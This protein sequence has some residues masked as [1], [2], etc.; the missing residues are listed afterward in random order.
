MECLPVDF[1]QFFA[2]VQQQTQQQQ[3]QQIVEELMPEEEVNAMVFSEPPDMFSDERVPDNDNEFV[4]SIMQEYERGGAEP[5]NQ[6]VIYKPLPPSSITLLHGG[7]G[8]DDKDEIDHIDKQGRSCQ[9]SFDIYLNKTESTEHLIESDAPLSTIPSDRSEEV[10]SK[11]KPLIEQ[12][13]NLF[14]SDVNGLL[15]ERR[16]ASSS[17]DSNITP[18]SNG[19]TP[20]SLDYMQGLTPRT[21]PQHS[22]DGFASRSAS[23]VSRIRPQSSSS[24]STKRNKRTYTPQSAKYTSMSQDSLKSSSRNNDNDKDL[25]DI[26]NIVDIKQILDGNGGSDVDGK[27][28]SLELIRQAED[29]IANQSSRLSFQSGCCENNTEQGI[30]AS[31]LQTQKDSK[32]LSELLLESKKIKLLAEEIFSNAGYVPTESTKSPNQSR[33]T[34]YKSH[35][36]GSCRSGRIAVEEDVIQPRFYKDSGACDCKCDICQSRKKRDPLVLQQDS[37]LKNGEIPPQFDRCSYTRQKKADDNQQKS[38]PRKLPPEPRG[39][40]NGSGSSCDFSEPKEGLSLPDQTVQSGKEKDQE[41]PSMLELPDLNNIQ[42]LGMQKQDNLTYRV[43]GDIKIHTT[44]NDELSRKQ[45]NDDETCYVKMEN[46]VGFGYRTFHDKKCETNVCI[47]AC[48]Y[49]HENDYIEHLIRTEEQFEHGCP[50]QRPGDQVLYC[51]TRGNEDYEK[52]VKSYIECNKDHET[53]HEDASLTTKTP[54][55]TTMKL[56]EPP[57]SVKVKQTRQS[58]ILDDFRD[59]C[60]SNNNNNRINLSRD[61]SFVGNRRERHQRNAYRELEFLR[62]RCNDL[63]RKLKVRKCLLFAILFRYFRY[64]RA[65][66]SSGTA[67]STSTLSS[68]QPQNFVS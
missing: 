38:L 4:L 26:L 49:A 64:S 41:Y 3:Q 10:Q 27:D 21:Q 2:D 55:T 57:H 20:I 60:H 46:D 65:L 6:S 45:I 48:E 42:V 33:E 30:D 17:T 1:D 43:V 25:K 50:S 59:N 9:T 5:H 58:S 16:R 52:Y 44:K 67:F 18:R 19:V 51:C 62:E 7:D 47:D 34:L 39:W 15:L 66:Y 12:R 8:D 32:F 37:L 23:S 31:S 53:L 36:K 29:M 61:G 63:A 13:Q 11:N 28:D 22:F 54:M 35:T 24:L 40:P 68:P 56:P 14:S